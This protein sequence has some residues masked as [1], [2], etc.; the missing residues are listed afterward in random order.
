MKFAR[1]VKKVYAICLVILFVSYSLRTNAVNGYHFS[2]YTTSEGLSHN[3]VWQV[4]QDEQGIIWAATSDGVNRF[5]GRQFVDL[6]L[7]GGKQYAPGQNAILSLTKDKHGFVWMKAEDGRFFCY[8]PVKEQF[9]A[10]AKPDIRNKSYDEILVD[11]SG[12]NWLWGTKNGC[13]RVSYDD[14][15]FHCIAFE[16]DGKQFFDN[17]IRMINSSPD[18]GMIITADSGIYFYTNEMKRVY[19]DR[20]DLG[21]ISCAMTR[22][23]LFFFTQSKIVLVYNKKSKLF[24]NPVSLPDELSKGELKEVVQINENS[25]LFSTNNSFYIFDT[26][27]LLTQRAEGLLGEKTLSNLSFKTD[28]AK[29]LWVYD[30]KGV[31]WLYKSDGK[32]KRIQLIQDDADL[33]SRQQR[34]N[35]L[36]DSRGIFWISTYGNGLFM[37][38][39]KTENLEHISTSLNQLNTISSNDILTLLEDKS[40]VLWVGTEYNGITRITLPKYKIRTFFPENENLLR[41]ENSIMAIQE[42]AERNLW[43][44]SAAGN[45]NIYT[46][47]GILKKKVN[48]TFAWTCSTVD[49]DNRIWL[50]SESDGIA[51]YANEYAVPVVQTAVTGSVGSLSGNRVNALLCDKKN[52]IW[53]GLADKGLCIAS[54]SFI[55]EVHLGG[56]PEK[57]IGSVYCMTL[58]SKGYIWAG[59]EEGLVVFNP[60]S[61]LKN[62]LRYTFIPYEKY[63]TRDLSKKQAQVIHE[64]KYGQL[65]IG[66]KGG[67]MT[68]Y[69]KKSDFNAVYV[70]HYTTKNGLPND[71]VKNIEEDNSGALW[72]S[73][74]YGISR[75]NPDA[76]IFENY[77]FA[78]MN[79]GNVYNAASG[80]KCGSGVLL[81]GSKY[82]CYMF[83]P[84]TFY[85]NSY[86]PPVVITNLKIN[87]ETV[88][89]ETGSSSFSE[90]IS[91]SKEIQLEYGKDNLTFEFLLPN[92]ND[93]YLNK[94]SYI[95][96]GFDQEWSTPSIY[97]QATYRNL[98]AGK[99][100]LKIKACNSAGV[101]NAQ[102]TEILVVVKPPLWRSGYAFF[103]YFVAIVLVLFVTYR[104]VRKINLLNTQ[105]TVD[106]ELGKYKVRFLSK[107]SNELRMPMSSI[108]HS[109]EEIEKQPYLT[110]HIKNQVQ[111]I[112]K[113]CNQLVSMIDMIFEH[114]SVE[115]EETVLTLEVT[116][117]VSFVYASFQEF[118]GLAKSKGVL[119]EFHSSEEELVVPIDKIKL[120]KILFYLLS[121]ELRSVANKGRVSLEIGTDQD[122]VSIRLSDSGTDISPEVIRMING[123]VSAS[124]DLFTPTDIGLK[125]ASDLAVLHKGNIHFEKDAQGCFQCIITLSGTSDVYQEHDFITKS[126]K[127]GKEINVPE[128][129]FTLTQDKGIALPQSGQLKEYSVL[130][131]DANEDVRLFL[132]EELGKYFTVETSEDGM[133]A[134]LKVSQLKPSL[135][136]VDVDLPKKDAYELARKI[137]TNSQTFHIPIILLSG[138]PSSE[139]QL[140][141]IE[142][143]ADSF[144][145]KPFSLKY[146]ITRIIKLIE[147]QEQF[148]QFFSENQA[149]AAPK[150]T[151]SEKD[152]VFMEDIQRILDTNLS[153]AEFSVDDFAGMINL[154][155]TVFFKRLKDL[156][157]YS[158][159]DYI[160][161]YR[162]KISAELLRTGEYTVSEVGYKVGFK[163]PFY[164]SRR[165]KEQ[166]GVSPSVYQKNNLS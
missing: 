77:R 76:R 96:E 26:E 65:W 123:E 43:M 55:S 93:D 21:I 119:Y 66:T 138:N 118:A 70:E 85:R 126:R 30:D 125:Q 34:Y 160:R 2:T 35:F 99:Y 114:K 116:D 115:V 97:N 159:N 103:F 130:V 51:C 154:G 68:C 102:D 75:F 142:A 11:S 23:K 28:N 29:N 113:N 161:V 59:A 162:L 16:P 80:V 87:G 131:A 84:N 4:M 158:P 144:I 56:I 50:G 151:T 13:L 92:Y 117:M 112:N 108:Q 37:Y 15:G 147:K 22:D 137:K 107:M 17:A 135:V 62:P 133:D 163:D 81:F 33:L 129:F 139:Y 122:K 120:G 166:Y 152:R 40:G 72:I 53:I 89:A 146:L 20:N 124:P 82:G 91:Y 3:T 36:L 7:S 38:D 41:R 141:A 155:R 83:N 157:G 86:V 121:R 156:T 46:E 60:D 69:V 74:E 164:F 25:V 12:V 100:R 14:R 101:W 54:T 109:V 128:S 105:T 49:S 90:A 111:W 88:F 48:S 27:T 44:A 78:N 153:N 32:S 9:V 94:Y 8:D 95:L 127:A 47:N 6:N 39:P 45:I 136:I 143:G 98:P 73:T 64:D 148:K 5:D 145:T 165:F 132:E 19:N 140:K 63:D 52:R 67:G 134:Y 42:D 110:D 106:K 10:Y 1:S 57:P 71:I 79:L 149:L 18:I 31:V 61:I 150:I 104:I 58:D 24:Q